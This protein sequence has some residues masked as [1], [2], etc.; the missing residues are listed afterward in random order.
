L[1][2]KI[3]KA[4]P[5]ALGQSFPQ[6]HL[7]PSCQTVETIDEGWRRPVDNIRAS[8]EG[9]QQVT[10]SVERIS[11]VTRSARTAHGGLFLFGLRRS[12]AMQVMDTAVTQPLSLLKF[13]ST[14]RRSR[15]IDHP[16]TTL[17]A[18]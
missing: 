13:Q 7:E 6:V 18:A 5:P 8:T 9:S 17:D 1:W 3:L 14:R 4:Q 12:A 2:L 11:G 10:M 16:R 15:R